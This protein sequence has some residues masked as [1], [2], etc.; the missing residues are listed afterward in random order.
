MADRKCVLVTGA[1]GKVGRAFLRRMYSPTIFLLSFRRNRNIMHNIR[2]LP[3]GHIFM[4]TLH[5]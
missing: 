2:N 3:C 1:T 5:S 4:V